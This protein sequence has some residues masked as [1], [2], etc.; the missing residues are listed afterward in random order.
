MIDDKT[1]EELIESV[2]TFDYVGDSMIEVRRN[3][4]A[5][6]L[7]QQQADHMGILQTIDGRLA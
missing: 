4:E 5:V 3:L 7:Q 2:F 6:D 1:A